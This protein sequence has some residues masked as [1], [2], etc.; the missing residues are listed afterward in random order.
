[1]N[2]TQAEWAALSQD[3]MGLVLDEIHERG[4]RAPRELVRAYRMSLDTHG[5]QFEPG[6][7][8]FL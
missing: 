1:M 2:R 7:E 5:A 4:D 8:M 6:A 3:H